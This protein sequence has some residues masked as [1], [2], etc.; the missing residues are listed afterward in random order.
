MEGK[1]DILTPLKGLRETPYM[2]L[3]KDGRVFRMRSDA[4]HLPRYLARGF[5]IEPQKPLVEEKPHVEKPVVIAKGRGKNICGYCGKK[6]KNLK[7]HIL[8]AHSNNGG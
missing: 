6:C 1:D 2:T 7:N 8:L 5:T 3:Y 4:F